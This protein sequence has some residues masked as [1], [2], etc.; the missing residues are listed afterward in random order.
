MAL[1]KE[2]LLK[3]GLDTKTAEAVLKKIREEA[4][5]PAK[6]ELNI[7]IVSLDNAMVALNK[8]FTQLQKGL[9]KEKDLRY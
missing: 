2:I 6:M 1:T 4:E 9:G 5:K 3:L 7:D 8:F